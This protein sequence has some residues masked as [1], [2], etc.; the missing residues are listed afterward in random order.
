[1]SQSTAPD[2]GDIPPNPPSSNNPDPDSPPPD[3]PTQ[4]PTQDPPP[5]TPS[6]SIQRPALH[7]ATNDYHGGHRSFLDV[8]FD[9]RLG[10]DEVRASILQGL[11]TVDF[12]NMRRACRSID[13]CLMMPSAAGSLRYPPDLVD[14]CHET[15]LPMPPSLPPL[16]SCPNPPQNTVRIRP[17][18]YFHHI[19]LRYGN[20]D[21][22]ITSHSRDYLV[23]EV[24]RRNW[25][26][27]IGMN[28]LTNTQ[29]PMS[30]HDSWRVL[31]AGAHITVCRL[32]DQEQKQQHSPEGHDGCVCYH[33]YY[34]KW[35]LCHRCDLLNSEHVD[36]RITFL[37]NAQR[38]NL[39]QVGKLMAAMP[40]RQGPADLRPFMSWCPCGRR[41]TEASPPPLQTVPTPW[42][43]NH[44]LIAAALNHDTGLSRITTK[45]CVLCCGYI[46]PPAPPASAPRRQPTRRSARL[47]DR[48]SGRQN[49]RI[50]TMLGGNG[51]AATR[52][53]VSKH[54]F[55]VRAR[56]G[57]N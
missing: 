32:C 49:N 30:R 8:I 45:Q 46:V 48:R 14:R 41:E 50:H 40:N 13:H 51:K 57:W 25:H 55:E 5:S 35:W 6:A 11:T 36:R 1:M 21:Q 22:T 33:E 44:H 52:H 31:L 37:T 54:G 16:G 4:D 20:P 12:D 19:R 7:A 2:S 15:E 26:D 42:P 47:A 27:N 24:C 43:G 9:A 28:P 17:C 39:K 38:Q 29:N 10:Y 34:K 18:Q 56:G 3:D 23:C 53:G